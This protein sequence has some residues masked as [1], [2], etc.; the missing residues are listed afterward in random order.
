MTLK[1]F[2][3]LVAIVAL[4][5]F[6]LSVQDPYF[7]TFKSP[8]AS[9]ENI[10]I[11][12]IT[13][14]EI[15]Q[16]GTK[17]R[18]KAKSWLRYD[19]KDVLTNFQAKNHK[20]SLSAKKAIKQGELI[21]LLGNVLYK[22]KKDTKI[23]GQR[24]FYKVDEKLIYSKDKFYALVNGNIITGKKLDYNLLKRYLKIKELRAWFFE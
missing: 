23:L 24:L 19:D 15:D 11:N 7:L 6:V 13:L 4:V 14:Y 9:I 21:T 12:N 3:V 8:V 2:A 5:M 1:L 16:K 22:D 17:A 10:Q 20:E 18:Y